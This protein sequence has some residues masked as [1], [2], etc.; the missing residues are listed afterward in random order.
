MP[1]VAFV[2]RVYPPAGGATGAMLSEM[3]EALVENGWEVTVVTGPADAPSSEGTEDG[4][5]V[6][7]VGG[8]SFTRDSTW[9]R[10]WAYVS[11]YPAFLARLLSIPSPDVIVTKTDPPMLKVLGPIVGA[12]TGA[13]TVHW[14]QDLYPEIA[15]ELGVISKGG[16]LAGLMRRLST[17][18]LRRH[19]HVAAVGR[20]MKERIAGRGVDPASVSVVPNWPPASVRP[21]PHDDNPFRTEHDLGG[22]FVVMYSGNM[23][24]AHPFD[25][26]LDAAERLAATDPS[27]LV[28]FV[29]DGPRKSDLQAA[30]A[31]R[32][33]DNVRFLP[34]QPYD[35]LAESLSAAD[36]HLVTMEES[37]SGLVVP[38]KIYGVMQAGRPAVFLGPPDSEAARLLRDH[39]CGTVLADA[40]GADLA[41]ALRSWRER[42]DRCRRAGDRAHEAVTSQQQ[43]SAAA[44]ERI[45]RAVCDSA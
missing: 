31:R 19:D 23:G 27:V 29:G 2:N 30:V 21:I 28:L 11:L 35:R 5:R 26:V 32:E 3:A 8:A 17:W 6:E 22:R 36:V 43:R 45:L 33:L 20:C 4:V 40:S 42:P 9:R 38:S 44:F 16:A 25:A 14:A 18:A 13:K 41:D 24:L 10:A 12:L 34:F 15:E 1:H 37:A 39:D 7:R